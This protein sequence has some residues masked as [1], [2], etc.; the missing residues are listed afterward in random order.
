MNIFEFTI[1]TKIEFGTDSSSRLGHFVYRLGGRAIIVTEN[2]ISQSG[3]ISNIENILKS[4]GIDAIIYDGVFP[5]ADSQTIDEVALIARKSRA[6]V[7]IGIGGMRTCNVAR[8]VSFLCRNQGEIT[9]FI[10]GKEGSGQ[11]ATCI[12]IPTT[13]REVYAL[14]GSA[15]L[16]DTYD[17]TNKVVA[18]NGLGADIFIIDPVLMSGLPLKTA[19]YTGLDILSLSIEGYISAKVNPLVEPVLLR[20]VEIIYYNLV[21]FI[22]NPLDVAVREKLCTAGLF[23]SIANIITGFGIGYAVSMGMN[24]KNRVSKAVASSILLPHVMGYNLSVAASRFAKIAR[25]MGRDVKEVPE[26]DA[27]FMAVD[28][29]KQFKQN[30]GIELSQSLG[31]L[32]LQKDDLAEAAEVAVHFED[33][34]TIPRKASFENLMEVLEKA[35]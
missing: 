2:P 15:F 12:E 24:G 14:T 19:V 1:P 31:Q 27:A 25:V 29:V 23:T 4:K 22:K 5:N 11:R 13:F 30:L 3:I 35:Y 20:G 18:L 34:N 21:Q 32:G 9:D 33:I 26:T 17:Q 8:L 10:R 28:A 6:N 16:T 7:V